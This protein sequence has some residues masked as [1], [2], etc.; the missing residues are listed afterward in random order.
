MWLLSLK[1]RLTIGLFLVI[2]GVVFISL[3]ITFLNPKLLW[4]SILRT[5]LFG[6]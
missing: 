6:W 2:C 4:L 1:M 5:H 3:C